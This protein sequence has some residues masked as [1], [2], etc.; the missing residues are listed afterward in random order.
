[1]R[2]VVDTFTQI[3]CTRWVTSFVAGDLSKRSEN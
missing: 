1:M 3:L 2:I